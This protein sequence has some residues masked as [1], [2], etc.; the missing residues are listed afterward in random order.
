MFF[1]FAVHIVLYIT[2]HCA[3]AQ[4][5]HYLASGGSYEPPRTPSGYAPVVFPTPCIGN[6]TVV[7][8]EV[9]MLIMKKRVYLRKRQSS[10]NHP[11]AREFAELGDDLR[12]VVFC[13]AR[14]MA[15]SMERTSRRPLGV[16]VTLPSFTCLGCY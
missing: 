13:A 3:H 7:N 14:D 11:E 4:F 15:D 12:N 2:V 6:F 8:L 16:P 9:L 1:F 10:T 5:R